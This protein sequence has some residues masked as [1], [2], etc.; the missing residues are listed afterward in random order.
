MWKRNRTI[1]IS[2]TAVLLSL[3]ISAENRRESVL[4]VQRLVSQL[5]PGAEVEVRL[6]D[7]HRVR[8]HVRAIQSEGFEL[9]SQ[10]Q[11]SSFLR[12]HDVVTLRLAKRVYRSDKERDMEAAR[13]VACA[14]GPGRHVLTRIRTGKTY[15]GNIA[16][17]S[18]EG[19]TLR[20]D[21]T[22]QSVHISYNEID[23]L[24]QNLSRAAK[25]G[26]LAAIAGV[27]VLIIILMQIEY[28][29]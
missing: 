16:T 17:V 5:G 25:I 4:D 13:R 19:F 14:L 28:D 22:D 3:P 24:E 8:G 15:R 29:D 21:H 12:Y 11:F 6:A 26:I 18:T 20:L 9:V 7:D 1:A 2:C 27:V 10:K 23:H